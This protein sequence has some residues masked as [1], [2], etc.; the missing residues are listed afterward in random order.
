M[1]SR[2]CLDGSGRSARWS[3]PEVRRGQ[4]PGSFRRRWLSV[5]L[6]ALGVLALAP[7]GA[8]AQ[9]LD[10]QQTSFA[11]GGEP[12]TGPDRGAGG[13]DSAAQ[14]FT[15]GLSGTLERVDLALSQASTPSVGPLTVEIRD[16]VGGAP[17]TTVLASTEVPQPDVPTG[18]SQ[19]LAFV[20]VPFASPTVVA[21]G[22]QYAI[23]VYTGGEDFYQWGRSSADL[24]A[25]GSRFDSFES[26]PVTWGPPLSNDFAFRTYVAS[27]DTT[28]PT[29][30]ATADPV[31]QG[32]PP[33]S[34]TATATFKT[35]TGATV[36]TV[37]PVRCWN[38]RGVR[39]TLN[40]TDNP[41]GSGVNTLSYAASGAQPIPS[42]TVPAAALPATVTITAPGVTTLTYSASDNAGNQ[43]EPNSETVL[44]G[45][46]N[47]PPF[48]C[49]LPTPASFTIP[50]HGSVT[51][52]GTAT[53][54]QG[55]FPFSTTIRY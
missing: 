19:A 45:P 32:Q 9:T 15:A 34:V 53:I 47:R 27:A 28:A 39:V 2:A 26:P 5:A 52:T 33:V 25:G 23:V 54:G 8:W 21:A 1:L 31:A 50:A 18:G 13:G 20:E 38:S 35:T 36:G 17:G 24:Y 10:Q 6:V 44:V 51:V 48:A 40:A 22:S 29:S 49:A 46:S 41:G 43:E 3:G 30:T 37:G 7:A 16:V 42:T 4:R 11:G 14:T 12:V 55:T